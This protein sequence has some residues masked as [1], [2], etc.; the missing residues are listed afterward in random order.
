M[1]GVNGGINALIG[2]ACRSFP[3]GHNGIRV[4]LM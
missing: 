1:G 3:S 2:H 4:V